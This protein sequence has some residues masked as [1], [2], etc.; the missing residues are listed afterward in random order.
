MRIALD[1]DGTYT[2]D[3][4]LWD[5]FILKARSRCHEV[6]IVTMRRPDEPVAVREHVDGVHYTSRKAKKV[7]MTGRGQDFQIWIDDRPEWLFVGG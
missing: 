2:A 3:P 5:A 4:D 1:Y 7:E 6:H